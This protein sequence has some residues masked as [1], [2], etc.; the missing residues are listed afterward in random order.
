MV[1]ACSVCTHSFLYSL[2]S[3]SSIAFSFT[4]PNPPIFIPT[5]RRFLQ[6]VPLVTIATLRTPH[7]PYGRTD[8]EG[9]DTLARCPPSRPLRPIPTGGQP[10]CRDRS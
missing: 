9:R 5:S 2:F 8:G 4:H 7:L 3:L 6:Q 10:H 1:S